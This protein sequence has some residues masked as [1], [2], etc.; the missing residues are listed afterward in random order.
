[1]Q[2]VSEPIESRVFGGIRD[3]CCHG[4]NVFIADEP[5]NLLDRRFRSKASSTAYTPPARAGGS[6]VSWL[7][8]KVRD[9]G[10]NR[11]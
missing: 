8:M 2:A 5:V 1:V 7:A 10:K 4:D 9:Q 6:P 3:H 11:F